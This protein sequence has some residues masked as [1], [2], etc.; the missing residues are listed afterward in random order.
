MVNNQYFTI[1]HSHDVELRLNDR[2]KRI[3]NYQIKII[4]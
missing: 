1:D 2:S 4:N 3:I